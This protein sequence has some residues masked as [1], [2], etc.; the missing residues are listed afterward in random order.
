LRWTPE[1]IGAAVGAANGSVEEIDAV[2]TEEI[3]DAE[4]R[5]SDFDANDPADAREQE[6]ELRNDTIDELVDQAQEFSDEGI[7]TDGHD[8]G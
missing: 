1:Q 5:L 2:S 8:R 7:D 6:I 4:D 3:A